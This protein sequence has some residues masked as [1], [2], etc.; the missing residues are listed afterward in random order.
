[1]LRTKQRKFTTLF[2]ASISSLALAACGSSSTTASS[3]SAT[4]AST[5]TS[6]TKQLTDITIAEPLQSYSYLPLYIAQQE[7]YFAKYGLNVHVE[8]LD[9][10]ASGFVDA[11][12]RGSV[13]GDIGGPEHDAYANEKGAAL[14][15]VANVVNISNNYLVARKGVNTSLPLAQQLKGQKIA[16]SFYGG[17][18]NVDLRYWLHSIGLT[19][20]VNV[21]LV[22]SAAS[23]YF[24]AVKS[25]Q[26]NYVVTS[27]P[28][29]SQGIADGL[30][31]K[32]IFNF[33]SWFGPYTY[34]TINVPLK[35]ITA[36]PQQVKDV[37]AAI[38]KAD[39][40]ALS[41][42]SIAL[43][44]AEKTFPGVP[45]SVLTTSYQRAVKDKMWAA[46]AI[47][48]DAAFETDVKAITEVGTYQGPAINPSSV[49]YNKF[50]GGTNAG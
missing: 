31:G 37:V 21:T 38:A 42:P 48:T 6:Q 4:T 3:T 16:V 24:G 40:T 26:V 46:N 45:A 15:S 14:R 5:A 13:W 7:G 20:G 32:P 36:N 30:W 1:M 28:Q 34:S 43:A 39:N 11:V 9:T 25:G 49:I 19:P 8:T 35:T 17:T 33:A 18:P 23:T 10:S 27:D 2:V 22:E 47:Q 29:L 50:L 44:V 41:T 12:L